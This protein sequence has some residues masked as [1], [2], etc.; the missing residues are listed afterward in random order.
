VTLLI[1][2]ASGFIGTGLRRELAASGRKLRLFVRKPLSNLAPHE[3]QV[4]GDI[5]DAAAVSRAMDGATSGVVHLA[6]CTTDA[7]LDEQIDGN[8]RG[9]FHIYEAARRC[10]VE[11]VVFASSNHVVGYYSRQRRIDHQVLLR[12]DSRYGLFKGF[13]EQAGALYAD[14]Y[15]LRVL[16]IRIGNVN[17]KPIDRRRL[18]LWLSWR[19]LVQLVEIGL[20]H[21]TLR[22]E[23]VYGVSGNDRTFYDNAAAFRLGYRPQDNAED[24]A[25]EV[26]ASSP[27]EDTG[28]PG[29]VAMGGDQANLEF[30][31]PVQRLLEW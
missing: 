25:A 28:L 15:G 19:D 4:V 26:L 20:T 9:A 30:V 3:E 5:A 8:I 23:V 6:G 7:G 1:T 18:A 2:G 22:Y 12:P 10:G 21:P 16:C 11:R 24:Y 14:K 27:P 13:G 17:D 29:T 31:P